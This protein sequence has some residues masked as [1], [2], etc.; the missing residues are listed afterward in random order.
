MKQDIRLVGLDLDGTLL[1]CD[2]RITPRTK[3]A[4]QRANQ[5]GCLVIP[6]TGRAVQDIPEEFLQIPGV[7]WA[8]TTNGATVV[9]LTGKNEPLRFWIPTQHWMLAQQLTS[10]LDVAQDV[11]VNG[12]GYTSAELLERVEEWAPP[13]LAEYIRKSRR[14]L[15]D[16]AEFAKQFDKVEKTNLFFS[17]LAQRQ[18]ARRR[19]E[20]T[21]VFAV[22]SS[23]PNN[24]ELNAA[25]V[26]KG[27]AL[28]ALAQKLGFEARQVMACG[29]SENDADM[30]RAVGLS[31][32]MGNASPQIQS[33][34]DWVTDTNNQ[35]GV[36][37][38]L[39]RFVPGV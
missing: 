23:A 29:D 26:N 10:D 6:A 33:L 4:I 9:D 37:K 32:A 2:Q 15:P 14:P 21:G 34:A 12:H 36:A 22:T 27:R 11:F 25:G 16:V 38:A 5:A 19:L 20:K 18:E 35:D 30:L 1:T 13:G 31:V 17:D 28:L 7:D 24:L 39:E 8:V 3:R